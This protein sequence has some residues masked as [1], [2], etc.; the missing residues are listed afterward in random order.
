MTTY[1]KIVK[2]CAQLLTGEAVLT[3]KC[4]EAGLRSLETTSASVSLNSHFNY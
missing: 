1:V 2:V 3:G 4:L